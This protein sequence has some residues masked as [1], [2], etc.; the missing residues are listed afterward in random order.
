VRCFC[1]VAES[2]LYHATQGAGPPPVAQIPSQLCESKP[3][4]VA[5]RLVQCAPEHGEMRVDA[6][7]VKHEEPNWNVFL[8]FNPVK[9]NA[10]HLNNIQTLSPYLKENT[11]LHHYKGQLFNAV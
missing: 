10:F 8:T 6:A 2:Q 11:T 3:H 9:K 1:L 5:Q 7:T 4:R